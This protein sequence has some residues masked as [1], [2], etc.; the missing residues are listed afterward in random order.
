[1]EVVERNDVDISK[2]FKW[3][4]VYEIINPETGEADGLI[5]MRLLGDADM[6][7]ARVYALR[8]SA[9]MRAKL[10][11]PESDE[12]LAYF[13]NQDDINPDII[14]SI[15]ITLSMRELYAKAK[16]EV[17]IKPPVQPKSTAPLEEME[18]YQKEL[19]EYPEKRNREISEFVQKEIEAMEKLLKGLP[20]DELYERYK[21]IFIQE[22]CEQ[23]AL[24]A[25]NEMQV[26]LGCYRDSE[27]KTRFF[28]SFEDFSNLQPE[29]KRMI[30]DAF[31]SLEMEM[32]ELKK[33]R[34]VTP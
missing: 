23:V 25:F 31:N 6:N 30:M 7:R 32:G 27:Y 9:E 20:F 34:R 19:D 22:T 10:K 8:K 14:I 11:D 24:Q 28:D 17:K 29:I 4:R 12:Y 26:Y 1:M 16:K 21:K 15:I 13:G 18:R 3:G 2:L 5:Y 33:L